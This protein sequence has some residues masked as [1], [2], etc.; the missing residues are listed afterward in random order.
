M[1]FIGLQT[2][3]VK[4]SFENSLRISILNHLKTKVTPY[5]LLFLHFLQYNPEEV[6]VLTYLF[7]SFG[8]ADDRKS[9]HATSSNML[10]HFGAAI[11]HFFIIL[12]CSNFFLLITLLKDS[13][14][15]NIFFVGYVNKNKVLKT[16][17][18]SISAI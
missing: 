18:F 5:T 4:P 7:F 3:K 16:I 1:S 6:R 12:K 14:L 15:P 9:F 10:L 8:L 13:P 2:F 17:K 11:M